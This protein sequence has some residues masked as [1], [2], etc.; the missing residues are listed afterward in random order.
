ML[1]LL[2]VLRLRN[3]CCYRH[4]ILQLKCVAVMLYA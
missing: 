4:T 3:V 1:A 2:R